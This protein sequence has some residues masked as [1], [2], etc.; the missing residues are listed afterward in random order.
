[1]LDHSSR[2]W[3][4]IM[5]AVIVATQAGFSQKG[6][7]KPN[8]SVTAPPNMPPFSDTNPFQSRPLYVSGNVILQGGLAPTEPIAIE[9]VCNGI[10]RREGYTDFKGQFQIQLGNSAIQFQDVSESPSNNDQGTL[11]QKMNQSNRTRYEGCELRA[12]LSGYQSTAVLLHITD[13]F[14]QVK[15]GNIVLTR[16]GNVEGATISLTSMAAPQAARQA[17]EKGR[18]AEGEKKYDE[19]EKHLNKAVELYPQY[20][21]AWYLLGE[22]HRF[23]KKSDQAISEYN[24]SIKSD[25]QFVSP[26]FG[27]AIIAVDQKRWDDAER[28]TAQLIH[29]NGMAFPLAYFYNSA[30]NYNMGKME[31]AE[32]SARKFQSLDTDHK[33]PDVCL[34]LAGI[35]QSRQDYAGAARELRAYLA[36]APK[37][38]KAAEIQAEAQRLEGMGPTSRN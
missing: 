25:P 15:V 6:G 30:A 1:M 37:S 21:S 31:A 3:I 16:M 10:A 17:Y 26:Y 14:G 9:R 20:A 7:N 18:K 12:L 13:D 27:L 34:L 28:S 29:L 2:R 33:V 24:Q 11:N 32:Q 19:A 4:T 5:A 35:L 38:P 8:T 36:Q 22:I 23:E